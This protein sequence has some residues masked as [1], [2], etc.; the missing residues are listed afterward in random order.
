MCVS[1]DPADLPERRT[2][3][4]A[5]VGV[6]AQLDQLFQSR[7]VLGDVQAPRWPMA[8]RCSGYGGSWAAW[9][10]AMLWGDLV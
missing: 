9:R 1:T 6:E 10:T 8:N 4:L 7:N 3:Q 5:E 2:G